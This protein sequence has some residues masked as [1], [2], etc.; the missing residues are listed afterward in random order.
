V[1]PELRAS[2]AVICLVLTD[3]L[4]SAQHTAA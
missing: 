2:P 3:G 4:R 1:L